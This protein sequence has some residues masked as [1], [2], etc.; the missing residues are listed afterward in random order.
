[1]V[2]PRGPWN[3]SNSDMSQGMYPIAFMRGIKSQNLINWSA[4][5]LWSHVQSLKHK[6][7]EGT[8]IVLYKLVSTIVYTAHAMSHTGYCRHNHI[9]T[10]SADV[11]VL[12]RKSLGIVVTTSPT[13]NLKGDSRAWQQRSVQLNSWVSSCDLYKMVV[14]PAPSR[15]RMRIR[16]S[17]EPPQTRE[18]LREETPC[19]QRGGH[20]LRQHAQVRFFASSLTHC[21]RFEIHGHFVTVFQFLLYFR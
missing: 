20:K 3:S 7:L 6:S 1:M 2:C 11:Y 4:I 21:Q 5:E 15:P 9:R 19:R 8:G 18:Q 10:H 12:L 17:L 16:V 13:C 14:L